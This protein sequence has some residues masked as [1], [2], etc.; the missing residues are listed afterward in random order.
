[1]TLPLPNIQGEIMIITNKLNLP[2]GF[3]KAVSTEKHNAPGSLS[4]TTLIQGVKQIILT[5]R[6]W[7]DLVDDVSDRIWA[8]FGSAVHSLMESEG[9]NNFTEQVMPYEVGGITVT[10]KIDNYDMKHGLIDDY[11]TA[12]VNKVKF[13]NFNDW[14]L[15][16]MIYA[17]LLWKNGFKAKHCRFITLLKDHSKTE[18]LRDSQYPKDPVY[19]YGF[20]VT[21]QGLFKIGIYIKDKVEEYRRCSALDD[22]AIPPCTPEERWDS[23]P[24]YAVMKNGVKKAVRLFDKRD[25]AD[26]LVETKGAGHYVEVRKGESR[27]CRSYCL[28]RQF[29]NFYRENTAPVID[30]ATDKAAA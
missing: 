8:I 18:V 28:C 14:Y 4:A 17:W 15:Q 2:E 26:L 27:R 13:R 20:P 29:C 22:D 16:G 1:M 12:S 23:P 9:E 10:G 11:K 24:K 21:S 3:V 6:H 7:D 19:I 25:D 5:D 30:A